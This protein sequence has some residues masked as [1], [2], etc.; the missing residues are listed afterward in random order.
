LAFTFF[1]PSSQTARLHRD[2]PAD[3]WPRLPHWVY[4]IKHDG[5]RF[6]RE[7]DRVRV[8]GSPPAA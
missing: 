3:Q 7:G 8:F 2:L 1:R 6:R 4:E 5:F